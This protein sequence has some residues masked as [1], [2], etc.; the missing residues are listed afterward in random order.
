MI[1]SDLFARL[2]WIHQGVKFAILILTLRLLW[3]TRSLLS[4]QKWQ[5]QHS[6]CETQ[7]HVIHMTWTL[8]QVITL[9]GSASRQT[10]GIHGIF[11][12]RDISLYSVSVA[13]FHKTRIGMDTH[14]VKLI[15]VK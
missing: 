2:R 15:V 14:S 7:H 4:L 6:R 11:L 5:I 8:L 10:P 13:T 3:T 9:N 12:I 1:C